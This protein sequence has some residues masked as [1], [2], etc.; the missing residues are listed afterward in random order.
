ME[1]P[2]NVN[3][4]RQLAVALLSVA[5]VAGCSAEARKARHLERGDGYFAE[6]QYREAVL[7]YGNV[8]AIEPTN[9]HAN[10]RL[11]LSH[12]ELGEFAPAFRH[13]SIARQGA[14]DDV[15]VR[16]K[17]GTLYLLSRQIDEA[18]AEADAVIAVEPANFEAL[19]LQAQT[20]ASLEERTHSLE[21]LE[22]LRDQFDNRAQYHWALA[23][24]KAKGGEPEAAEREL[25]LAAEKDPTSVQAHVIVGALHS[26]K[27]DFDNA[28]ASFRSAVELEKQLIESNEPTDFRAHTTLGRFYESRQDLERAE[29]IFKQASELSEPGSPQRVQLADF[30]MG[31]GRRDDAMQALRQILEEAPESGAALHRI[32]ELELRAG[33]L[34]ASASAIQSALALNPSDP[35]ATFLQGHLQIAREDL[36]AAVQSFQKILD[37]EPSHA[38]ARYSLG[39]ALER[40]GNVQQAKSELRRTID[41]NPDFARAVF[42]LARIN[43]QSDAGDV[44]IEDLTRFLDAHPNNPLAYAALGDAYR[45]QKDGNAALVNLERWRGQ[46]LQ[47]RDSGLTPVESAAFEFRFGEAHVLRGELD[48]AESAYMNALRDFPGFAP[49]HTGLGML[50]ARRG[51]SDMA[52]RQFTQA[53][54]LNPNDSMSNVMIGMSQQERGDVQQAIASY[55]KVLENGSGSAAAAAANN[56]AYIFI[57]SDVDRALELARRANE[58]A[59]NNAAIADTLGWVL[60]KT[61]E[62]AEAEPL[63]SRSLETLTDN[64]EVHYHLG[65]T[66]QQLGKTDDARQLL[67]KALELDPNFPGSDEARRVIGSR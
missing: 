12:L 40:Q 8:V 61:G 37:L 23:D 27:Q 5:L 44:A 6:K 22:G 59:P 21:T 65:M 25:L 24:L 15:A 67:Q 34:D 18:R 13:L 45:I 41:A 52:Q 1:S 29:G 36:P 55:E 63:L 50:Y 7:E 16:L 19:I 56:L 33:N 47:A 54:E 31:A 20:A 2:S 39:V 38:Y 28:E 62:Y 14:P 35:Q 26:S 43:L 11:G 32:A 10:G 60:F 46:I 53:L 30:Y 9:I 4:N 49:A 64:A 58:L 51:R 48:Q 57:D 3:R 17:L 42:E 66:R